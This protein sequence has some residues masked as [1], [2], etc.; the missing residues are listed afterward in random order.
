M[1]I[2]AEIEE[3]KKK[4]RAIILAHN[5][6]RPEVQDIADFVGDSLEL[7]REAVDVDASVI[8]FCGVMFMAEMATILNPDKVVL[9]PDNSAG[10]PLADTITPSDVRK[11]RKEHEG[12][13]VVAYVNTTASVKAEADICCTSANSVE[14]VQSL[15]SD[16]VIFVPDRNL[17]IYTQ[18]NSDKHLIIWEG[19]CGVHVGISKEDLLIMKR[20]HPNAKIVVHPECNPEV[21]DMADAIASTGG[22]VK[23]VRECDAQEFIIGTEM[24]HVY[25]L[26]R[27]FPDKKFYGLYNAVCNDMKKITLEKVRDSLKNMQYRVTVPDDIARKA[28]RA[29][30]RMLALR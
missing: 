30:E 5:Y 7:A 4:R 24:G 6:Q 28:R 22:M 20:M 29:I 19:A 3:L 1:D 10:C 12:V 17:G 2:I 26:S 27:L 13:P 14:V 25:R 18:K 16:E 9:I 15:E 23:Y 21:M 11:L 8:V